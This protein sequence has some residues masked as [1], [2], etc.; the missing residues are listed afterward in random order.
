[1][2]RKKDMHFYGKKFTLLRGF[3]FKEDLDERK[4]IAKKQGYRVLTKQVGK[5]EWL[6]YVNP[7]PDSLSKKKR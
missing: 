1:M 6:M 2:I 7:E 5:Y 3:R 4:K